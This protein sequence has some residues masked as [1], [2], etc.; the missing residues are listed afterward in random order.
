MNELR[1]KTDF[2]QWYC[3][4]LNWNYYVAL[5]GSIITAISLGFRPCL[6][7][8]ITAEWF[9]SSEHDTVNSLASLADPLG[10]TLAFLIVPFVA[11]EPSDLLYLQVY[12]F[13]PI[14]ISFIGSLLIKREGYNA[15]VRNQ[16]L[17]EKIA[18]LAV[19]DFMN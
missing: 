13:I 1:L 15:E 18:T 14:I 10:L 11:K 2:P 4:S 3:P 9:S 19:E 17:K 8:K 5:F 16:S 12:I 7:T 6:S